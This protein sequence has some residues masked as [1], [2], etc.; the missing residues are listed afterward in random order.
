MKFRREQ[1]PGM[2]GRLAVGIYANDGRPLGNLHL[3]LDQS[4]PQL[5]DSWEFFGDT[6]RNDTWHVSVYR[7]FAITWWMARR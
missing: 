2:P 4:E 6:G 1:W 5:L 7:W 3:W